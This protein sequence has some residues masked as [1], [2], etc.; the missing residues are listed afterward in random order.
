[1][2]LLGLFAVISVML[3]GQ[4]K[5]TQ[6]GG[7]WVRTMT[8]NP[9]IPQNTKLVVTS[10]GG[11]V[12]RGSNNPQASYRIVQRVHARSEE[13]ARQLLSSIQVAARTQGGITNF[14]VSVGSSL[15][16]STQL[17]LTVPTHIAIAYVNTQMG[18]V[19]A[20]DL[21]CSVDLTTAAGPIRV[22]RIH[23]AVAT[24]TGGGEI[25]I[26]KITGAARAISGAGSILVD[27]IG[28]EGNLDTAGGEITVNNSLG[29]LILSTAGGNISV[30]N[31]G[32]SVDARSAEGM[33]EVQKAAGIVTAATSGGSIQIGSAQGVR[34]ESA[35]GQV[36]LKGPSGPMRVSTAAGSILAELFSGMPLDNSSLVAGSGDITV[37]IPSNLAVSVMASSQSGGIPRIV[38]DFSEVRVNSVGLLRMP[39]QAQGSINGGGPVLTLNA[40]GGV[41]YLRRK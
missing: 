23:G 33:I 12:L 13:D 26:G 39:V 24:R 14:E 27:S 5:L 25:H 20:Y 31:A 10:R 16:A 38:S 36:R 32:G 34:A 17:E 37:L 11:V 15:L 40:T 9:P 28:G 29:K 1:M 41:I 4:E 6:E 21:D 7:S 3:F 35:Q 2:K 18:T 30:G 22:D 19:E 8:G